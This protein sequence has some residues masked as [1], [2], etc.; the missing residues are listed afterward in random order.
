[1]RE[2]QK[3]RHFVASAANQSPGVIRAQATSEG[4]VW[5]Q[6]TAVAGVFVDFCSLSYN[7]GS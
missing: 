3:K 5:A 4:H 1:M 2:R 7:K 6:E